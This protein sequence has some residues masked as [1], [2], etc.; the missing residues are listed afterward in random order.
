MSD[1]Y[2]IR[3]FTISSLLIA[4]LI[5]AWSA[6]VQAQSPTFKIHN[7]DTINRKDVSNY[8]Q[9]RWIIFG[10]DQ[11]ESGY[12]ATAIVEE[13]SYKDNR[14][15]GLWVKYYPN[16]NKKSEITYVN[17]RPRGP[18]KV[19]YENG[20]LEEDGNWK[21]NRNVG[22]FKRFYPNG[23]PQQAFEFN[24]TGKREGKQTYFH[25]N[26]AVMIEGDWAGGKE[27]GEVKEYYA[28]GSVK[29]VKYFNDGAIDPVKT[30]TFEPKTPQKVEVVEIA[31]DAPKSETVKKTEH[32]ANK[33]APPFDGNGFHIL[34][35]RNRQVSQKG[36][37]KDYRLWNG[38]RYKYDDDGLL[39][40]I[41]IFK[42]GRYVGD[43]V[44][45]EGDQ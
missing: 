36:E 23:Q 35:N 15:D 18:Y 44:I 10:A 39:V 40:A 43:G 20:Q 16:G 9:G 33:T 24:A 3:K 34:Y 21:N 4:V 37:F 42:R 27:S 31:A 41:E 17:N 1:S 14:K 45:E 6:G 22:S 25:E 11:S 29:S 30:Q 28:D 5:V 13:G 2:S 19:Y 38:K 12:D 32:T 7:G 8:K 26:G